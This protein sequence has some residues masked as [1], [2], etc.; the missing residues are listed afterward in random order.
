MP[1][2]FEDLHDVSAHSAI[3]AE[4]MSLRQQT[5]IEM[6]HGRE[7]RRMFDAMEHVQFFVKDAQGAFMAANHALVRQLGFDAEEE[8]IGLTDFDIHPPH[9]AKRLRQDD[10]NVMFHRTPLVDHVEALFNDPSRMAWHSTTKLPL[11]DVNDEVIGIMGVTWPC[12]PPEPQKES[13]PH[14]LQQVVEHV[15]QHCASRLRITELAASVDISPRRLNE[16]FQ[17]SYRMSAQQFILSTRVYAAMDD[18]LRTRKTFAQIAHDYGF[19]DQSAFTRHFRS[20]TGMT[21]RHFQQCQRLLPESWQKVP[22]I[23]PKR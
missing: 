11:L 4:M 9:I 17:A 7:I 3:S 22:L 10:W 21:P 23:L 1:P 5:F 16:L 6:G 14:A 15:R 8:I 12:A 18:L 19:V 2:R 20:F 13:V